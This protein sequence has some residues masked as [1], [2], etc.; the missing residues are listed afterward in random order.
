MRCDLNR[1]LRGTFVLAFALIAFG[2]ANAQDFN[3]FYVGGYAGGAFG[4]VSP[5]TSPGFSPTGYFA[6]TSTPAIATASAAQ[7]FS[8]DPFTAG[9]QVGF[10]RQWD[11]FVVGVVADFGKLSSSNTSSTTVTYPCCAPTAFTITQSTETSRLFTIRPRVGATVGK[12]LFYGTVG[13][14]FTHIKYS[15]LFTDTFATAHENASWDAGT[16]GWVAGAGGEFKVSHHLSVMGEYLYMGL[17]DQTTS[18]NL[19]AFTP[20]IPFPSN[21]FTH[22]VDLRLQVIR[23]GVNFRF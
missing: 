1:L 17:G 10:D 23:A 21:V 7:H 14:A 12:T 6:S 19:T 20:A 5:L 11:T 3:G 15:A 22:S 8:P 9:G 13:A 18:V 2:A 4:T 16:L